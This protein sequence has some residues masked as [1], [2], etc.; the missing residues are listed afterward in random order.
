MTTVQLANLS[1]ATFTLALF[2]YIAG[3]LGYFHYLIYRRRSVWVAAKWLAVTGVA[4]H[5][6]S[7]LSRG[8]AAHRVPWGNMYEYSSLL[9]LLVVA[10][11]LVIVEAKYKVRTLGGFVLAFS[12]L[13]MA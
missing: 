6:V 3:M 13:T 1:K 9:S 8:L 10:G 2:A 4:T 5:G 12:V 7:I 11:Y